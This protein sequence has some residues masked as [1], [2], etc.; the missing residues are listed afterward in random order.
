MANGHT[1]PGQGPD[2][3]SF[4]LGTVY[5]ITQLG[6]AGPEGCLPT[7]KHLHLAWPWVW[8]QEFPAA[9]VGVR[10]VLMGSL[11]WGVETVI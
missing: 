7:S 8:G 9:G 5:P 2:L 1:V 10:E 11:L 6:A 4:H 3:P